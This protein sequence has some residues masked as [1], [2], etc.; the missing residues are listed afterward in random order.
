MPPQGA[1]QTSTSPPCSGVVRTSTLV[2]LREGLEVADRQCLCE[3]YHHH[4]RRRCRAPCVQGE[5]EGVIPAEQPERT[6]VLP[7][8]DVCEERS[9]ITIS[10]ERYVR[11]LLE[12]A[13]DKEPP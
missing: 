10:Q 5:H 12:R 4:G 8:I 7:R 11:K 6:L 13:G 3:R 9:G 2:H 1:L